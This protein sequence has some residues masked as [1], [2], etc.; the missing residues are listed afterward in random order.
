MGCLG[1]SVEQIEKLTAYIT[2]DPVD[3]N[4]AEDFQDL[5]NLA[6]TFLVDADL[7]EPAIENAIME[8]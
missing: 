3:A 6:K 8:F 2:S 4:S 7:T 1:R 5:L